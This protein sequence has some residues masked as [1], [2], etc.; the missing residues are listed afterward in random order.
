MAGCK[1]SGPGAI[2]SALCSIT[3][4]LCSLKG[5]ASHVACRQ[6]FSILPSGWRKLSIQIPGL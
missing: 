6:V 3:L 5:V 4:I 2:F 1:V